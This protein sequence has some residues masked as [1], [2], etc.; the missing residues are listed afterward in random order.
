MTP[1]EKAVELVNRYKNLHGHP[2]EQYLDSEDS[3]MC[4]LVAVDELINAATPLYD[5]FWPVNTT[6]YWTEVKQEITNI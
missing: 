5:S 3:K 2:T 6:E 1:K 4:A